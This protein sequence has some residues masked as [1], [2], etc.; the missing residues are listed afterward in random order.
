[1]LTHFPGFLEKNRCFSLLASRCGDKRVPAF[2]LSGDAAEAG[3]VLGRQRSHLARLSILPAAGWR[4]MSS[5]PSSGLTRKAARGQ[6][7]E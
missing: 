6:R 5:P 4:R 3:L 1:M 7:I 2:W